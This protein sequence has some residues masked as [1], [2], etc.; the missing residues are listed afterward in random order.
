[1]INDIITFNPEIMG[2]KPCIR[3]MRVTVAMIVSQIAEGYS[4]EDILKAYPY[5][6]N[7][8]ISAALKYTAYRIPESEF[9]Q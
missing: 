2:G 6:N 3:G 8:D 1:M 9:F 7:E 4:R 5:L